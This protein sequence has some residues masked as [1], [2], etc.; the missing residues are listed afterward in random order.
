MITTASE[1]AK[2][3]LGRFQSKGEPINNL[4][5]QKLLYYSQA[6]HLAIH[7]NPLFNERIEAWT[8]G[9]VIPTVFQQYKAF[10]W[11]PI[12]IEDVSAKLPP[13]ATAHVEEVLAE[14]GKFT[15]WDLER[16][17]HNEDPWKITR[18]GLPADISSNSLI[19]HELMKKF[20]SKQ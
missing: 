3:I 19:T 9:P 8:H 10:R 14:Y 1:V 20:Y 6:W 11:S 17:T 16:M 5:L 15:S 12:S 7:G 18:G 2:F 4:K 13:K